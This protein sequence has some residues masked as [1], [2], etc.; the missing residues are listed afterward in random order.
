MIHGPVITDPLARALLVALAALA[1]DAA[2]GDPPAL[3]RRLPHP[4]VLIGRLIGWADTRFNRP[5]RRPVMN[6]AAGLAVA[7]FVVLTA[8]LGGMVI[9]RFGGWLDERAGAGWLIEGLTASALLAGR[10]LKEH[11]IAVAAGLERSLAD[12]R[13][14]VS[15]IVGRDPDSLDEAAVARAA[16]ESA[17]ENFSDGLA[18]PLFWLL[19]GG[20]PGLCAY[21]AV[22]T[23]DS[24]IGHL[25]PRYRHFGWAAARIDD[26]ANFIPARLSALLLAAAGALLGRGR[27]A[28]A[29][30]LRDAGHHRSPNAGW[31]E[32]AMGG[33]LDLALAGP[34]RYGERVVEDPFIGGSGPA[35]AGAIRRAVSLLDS[36]RLLM[37]AALTAALALRLLSI[38]L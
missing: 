37:A 27:A 10:S 34:R 31:P 12:G 2:I 35:D 33:A 15:A 38:T 17:A 3:Y 36:A 22:N 23:L 20:L 21:K 13:R 11:V 28:L 26:A 5:D 16:V 18:A 7:L 1:F 19:I 6:R 32:A 24:M 30:A 29:A 9:A 14:A 4:V 25:S 8:V